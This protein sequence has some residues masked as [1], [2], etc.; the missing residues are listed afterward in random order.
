MKK[1]V[2]L[3]GILSL[4][5][6][7]AGMWDTSGSA[8]G[9]GP[10]PNET[11]NAGTWDMSGSGSGSASTPNESVMWDTSGS[12]SGSTPNETQ[13]CA[14]LDQGAVELSFP[15][16]VTIVERCILVLQYMSV[17]FFGTTLNSFV[18][19]LVWRFK[20][21]HTIEFA[22]ATQIISINLFASVFLVPLRLSSVLANQWLLGEAMCTVIGAI[23]FGV[24]TLRTLLMMAFVTD[25]FFNVFLP[26]AYPRY[27][28]KLLG[29]GLAI[30]YAVTL[31]IMVVPGAIDCVS[32][33]VTTW[34]CRVNP[35]CKFECQIFRN[36]ATL[37]VLAPTTILP[38][39]LYIALFYKA[40]RTTVPAANEIAN[41]AETKKR[42]L[43]AVT[44]FSLM[45]LTLFLVTFPPGL[46]NVITNN[47]QPDITP[48]NSLWF[49]ILDA[50]TLNML[51]FTFIMDPIFIL[52]NRDVREALPQVT[53]LPPFWYCK[54]N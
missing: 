37:G 34:I 38:V 16:L 45:F 21:L 33:S 47:V 49:H 12:A 48:T 25:R 15:L 1:L 5:T 26:L 18:I 40:K 22:F 44:T 17:S 29:T 7:Y 51:I 2:L 13:T 19:Y 42:S 53:W 30:L 32:F 6:N 10:T 4:Q 9:S 43:R 36:V 14:A 8:N 41:D 50:V 35:R 39:L 24:T 3:L 52:R 46:L 20:T 54:Y 31:V 23:Q 27:R 28:T 11:V